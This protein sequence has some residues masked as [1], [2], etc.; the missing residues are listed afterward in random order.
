[1]VG[2][3]NGK[4][5]YLENIPD[6]ASHADE[7]SASSWKNNVLH[8]LLQDY[9]SVFIIASKQHFITD[10]WLVGFHA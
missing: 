3:A 8:V 1:M 5:K 7:A 2:C 6:E 4:K 9:S 10:L